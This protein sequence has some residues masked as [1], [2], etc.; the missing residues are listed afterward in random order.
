MTE[1]SQQKAVCRKK[2]F[3]K[4]QAAQRVNHLNDLNDLNHSLLPTV[5]ETNDVD[6]F[7]AG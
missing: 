7:M 5:L 2:L 6:S 4:V 1:S 3:K